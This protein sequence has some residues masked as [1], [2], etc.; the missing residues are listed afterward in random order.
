MFIS[1]ELFQVVAHTHSALNSD[2]LK[3]LTDFSSF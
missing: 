3:D 2:T 1:I